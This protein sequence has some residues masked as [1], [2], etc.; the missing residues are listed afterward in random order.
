MKARRFWAI[1]LKAMSEESRRRWREWR[2]VTGLSMWLFRLHS[3]RVFVEIRLGREMPGRTI[4]CRVTGATERWVLLRYMLAELCVVR[5][6]YP[7]TRSHDVEVMEAN[8]GTK[9][10]RLSPG[11]NNWDKQTRVISCTIP[12]NHLLMA[13]KKASRIM[14]RLGEPSRAV[15][16]PEQAVVGIKEAE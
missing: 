7:M 12:R 11:N 10:T 5:I 14:S 3:A 16:Y 8:D 4:R 9:F 1:W 15:H 2:R 13:T 6:E